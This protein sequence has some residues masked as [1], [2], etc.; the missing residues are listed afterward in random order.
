MDEKQMV[1]IW[2]L[3]FF[4]CDVFP[5]AVEYIPG[6]FRCGELKTGGDSAVDL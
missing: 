4:L 6:I 2:I 5:D 1:Q 3:D